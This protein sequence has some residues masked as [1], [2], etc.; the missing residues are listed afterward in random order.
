MDRFQGDEADIVIASLVVDEYSR[1][2]FV[3]LVNRMIVL[4][5][6]ARLG[7]YILGNTGYFENSRQEIKHWQRTFTLLQEPPASTDNADKRV[8][9]FD[10]P[11]VG[12]K[13]PLCCPQHPESTFDAERAKELQLGFC[14]ITCQVRLP[15]NHPCGL[16]CHWPQEKHNKKCVAM[17]AS[18][19][20]RHEADITCESVFANSSFDALAEC[21][22]LT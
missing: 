10:K 8:E 15:C 9:T 6:R 4:L 13:L 19:C 2:P 17:V 5:S 18:P 16:K 14:G 1:T 3:K 21:D 22:S 11:R 7:M 12:P 20:A